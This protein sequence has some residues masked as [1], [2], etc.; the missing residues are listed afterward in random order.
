MGKK[1]EIRVM[2]DGKEVAS[3]GLA[4]SE[5]W[6]DK[7]T[8]ERK[9][10]VEWHNIVIFNPN[11]VSI[12]KNYIDKGSKIYIEGSLQT[13]KWQD[14]NGQDKY[15]TEIVLQAFGGMLKLLDSKQN[16]SKEEYKEVSTPLTLDDE[17]PF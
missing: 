4:T 10:K 15:S 16:D 17:I 9:T 13:R 7:N 11:I 8:G 14:Q 5:V 12:V 2:K 3:F 6:K 1:P